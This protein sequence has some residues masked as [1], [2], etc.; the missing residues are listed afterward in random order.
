MKRLVFFLTIIMATAS[1]MWGQQRITNNRTNSMGIGDDLGNNM[2][3]EDRNRAKQN[4]NNKEVTD[5]PVDLNQWTLSPRFGDVRPTPV[6]TIWSLQIWM[7]ARRL[8]EFMFRPSSS[9]CLIS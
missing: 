8:L 5:V 3:E 2:T 6:D 9:P 1:T 7:P 4:G